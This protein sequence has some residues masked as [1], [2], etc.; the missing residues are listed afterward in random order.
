LEGHIA[1]ALLLF[2][3]KVI[4]ALGRPPIDGIVY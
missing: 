2:L 4:I 1:A 3:S